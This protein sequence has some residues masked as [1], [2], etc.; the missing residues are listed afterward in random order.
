METKEDCL[1]CCEPI[2]YYAIYPCGHNVCCWKCII[3]QRIK[4]DNEKCIYCKENMDKLL[5]SSNK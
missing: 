2:D 3:K 5:I 1:V 4:L